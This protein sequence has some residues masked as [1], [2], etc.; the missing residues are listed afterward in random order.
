MESTGS[1]LWKPTTQP[2]T[3]GASSPPCSTLAVTLASKWWTIS[4]LWLVA[5]MD[6]P[7]RSTLSATTKKLTSGSMLRT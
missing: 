5:L 7:P 4:C 6:M 1:A 3:R 2:P